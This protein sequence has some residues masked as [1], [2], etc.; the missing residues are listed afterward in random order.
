MMSFHT[1]SRVL[2]GLEE[3]E[4]EEVV[5]ENEIESAVDGADDGMAE[6]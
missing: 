4:E 2:V 3:E 1:S 6:K 5:D